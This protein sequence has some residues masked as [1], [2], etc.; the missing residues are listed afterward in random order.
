MVVGVVGGEKKKVEEENG[1]FLCFMY[2]V[3]DIQKCTHKKKHESVALLAY[4]C[5]VGRYI[6]I[7][8]FLEVYKDILYIMYCHSATHPH[9]VQPTSEAHH[10][11][12]MSLIKNH[13]ISH[14]IA[15]LIHLLND[16][17]FI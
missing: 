5:L 9:I 12:F 17:C 3:R 4:Y 13:C 10:L 6:S 11:S 15:P 16:Y 8:L 7:S 1:F 2:Y 14:A